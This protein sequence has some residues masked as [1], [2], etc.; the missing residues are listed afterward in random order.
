MDSKL[1]DKMADVCGF[2]S[3]DELEKFL[4]TELVH[5]VYGDIG[6][7]SNE[8]VNTI[9]TVV[10]K[11]AENIFTGT[12][13]VRGTIDGTMTSTFTSCLRRLYGELRCTI[14]TPTSLIAMYVTGRDDVVEESNWEWSFLCIMYFI[15][16][17]SKNNIGR[18]KVTDGTLMLVAEEI[19]GI[20]RNCK[21]EKDTYYYRPRCCTNLCKA[22][23]RLVD[24][25]ENPMSVLQIHNTELPL[26]YLKSYMQL[27]DEDIF[28][29]CHGYEV[30]QIAYNNLRNDTVQNIFKDIIDIDEYEDR[31]DRRF[32]MGRTDED[33]AEIVAKQIELS[34][35][36]RYIMSSKC[37]IATKATAAMYAIAKDNCCTKYSC[38]IAYVFGAAILLMK[39]YGYLSNPVAVFMHL[40]ES[41]PEEKDD[42]LRELSKSIV[43]FGK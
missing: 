35:T 15:Y 9:F 12:L 40:E 26:Q 39:D 18:I 3:H 42:M 16:F 19:S 22:L 10:M 25:Q 7:I 43:K 21:H 24:F 5:G 4:V 17:V 11:V 1:L 41:K 20:V 6:P 32:N 29:K 36:I 33:E 14:K 34:N 31:D 13:T 8:K 27:I 23:I 2:V 37:R 30:L 38:A 28:T